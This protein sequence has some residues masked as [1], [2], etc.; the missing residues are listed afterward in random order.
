MMMSQCNTIKY[1]GN[2]QKGNSDDEREHSTDEQAY[3]LDG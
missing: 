2:L 3:N 1:H